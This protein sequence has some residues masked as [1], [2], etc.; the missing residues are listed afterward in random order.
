MKLADSVQHYRNAGNNL[1]CLAYFTYV[2]ILFD[3]PKSAIINSLGG[4]RCCLIAQKRGQAIN[5]YHKVSE[6]RRGLQLVSGF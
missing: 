1:F 4:I 3:S 6:C 2:L 5:I